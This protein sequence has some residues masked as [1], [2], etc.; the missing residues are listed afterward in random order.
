MPTTSSPIYRAASAADV[1]AI[2]ALVESAYR[3]ESG[4]RGWTTETHLLDGQRTD[5]ANVEDIIGRDGSMVLLAERDGLLVGCCHV[6]QRGNHGYFG[7]FAISPELQMAGLGRA[8]LAE[9]ERI[10][11]EQW[12]LAAMR[13]SVIEQRAELIA[14]YERRGY[15]LTGET[16]AF[17]YGQPRFGI[18]RRDDLRFVYMSKSLQEVTA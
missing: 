13:M 16:G 12:Q 17:P 18:P 9:A 11:R 8:L 4:Q 5:A 1:P 2:V 15:R 6:E 14:W 7:M 10:A 3:G